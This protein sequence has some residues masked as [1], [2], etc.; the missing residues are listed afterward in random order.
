[1]VSIR[2]TARAVLA[3]VLSSVSMFREQSGATGCY[4]V[5]SVTA[6]DLSDKT[7]VPA[8][9]LTSTSRWSGHTES[10]TLIERCESEF[11]RDVYQELQRSATGSFR[12]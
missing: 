11:E 6:A 3:D 2:R 9:W 8:C 4:L 12:K 7:C 1:M 5:R 10:D